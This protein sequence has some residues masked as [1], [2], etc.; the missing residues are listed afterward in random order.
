MNVLGKIIRQ[1]LGAL[2]L[3]IILLWINIAV[4]A[5]LL[6]P[7]AEGQDPYM[8]LRHT[9]SSLPT[10]PDEVAKFGT[11]EGGYDIY[12]GIIWG[13]RTALLVGLITVFFN[14]VVGILVG[15]ISAYYGGVVDNIIMRIVDLFMSIP[16]L[17]AVI[18]MTT[19][20]GK[21]LDKIIIALIIFGWP[22]YARIMRSEVLSVK[23]QE[24]ILAARSM[25]ASPARIFLFHIL[26][27]SIHPIIVLI[28]LDIGWIALIAAA[29]SFMGIGSEPGFA[30]W[31]QMLNFARSWISGMP[32]KPF[33]YW[34]TYTYPSIAI[35]TFALGWTL[36]GDTLRDV[37]D[38]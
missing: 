16:F 35:F 26:P 28:S 18:V 29:Q 1:P 6:A 36:L 4:F 23:K 34:Y 19:V 11:T 21:G 15:G 32:G 33:Y 8:I 14:S 5:P 25:G 2:G 20:L 27:N 30:D 17:I 3:L 9:F 10:P 31:G 22:G 38:T 13:S 37:F 24:Y 7:P 12:Y